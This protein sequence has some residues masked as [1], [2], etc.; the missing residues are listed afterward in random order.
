MTAHRGSGRRRGLGRTNG[1]QRRLLR[2][3]GTGNCE[4]LRERALL[5]VAWPAWSTL[6]VGA[7]QK[8]VIGRRSA[9]LAKADTDTC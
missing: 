1:I 2:T 6:V 7:F 5:A 4:I 8:S 9:P 3:A